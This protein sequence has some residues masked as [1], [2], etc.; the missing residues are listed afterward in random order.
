MAGRYRKSGMEQVSVKLYPEARHE[1]LHER[2]REEVLGDLVSWIQEKTAK[3]AS[4]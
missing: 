2:C 1:L 3:Q 4:G